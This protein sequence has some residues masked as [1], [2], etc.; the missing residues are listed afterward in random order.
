MYKAF[1]FQPDVCKVCHDVL[2]V[3]MNLSNI[4]ILNINRADYRCFINRINKHK[5]MNLLQNANM[6]G[7]KWNIIQHS[8]SLLCIKDG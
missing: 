2:M 4:V 7:E 3:S 6:T 5:V 8:F 1:K